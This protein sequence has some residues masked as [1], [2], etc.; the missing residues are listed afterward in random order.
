[1]AAQDSMNQE[2][3]KLCIR[4]AIERTR[5]AQQQTASELRRDTQRALTSGT[6]IEGVQAWLQSLLIDAKAQQADLWHIQKPETQ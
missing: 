3:R 4:I 5:P 6:S 2:L 1:M